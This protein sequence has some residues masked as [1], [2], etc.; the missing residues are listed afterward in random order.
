MFDA[1]IIILDEPTTGLDPIS[2][3]RLKEII[4]EE[5]AKRKNYFDHF[6][7]HEFCRRSF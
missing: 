5:K 4:Q 3:I 1:E 7:Y 2:L 6:S